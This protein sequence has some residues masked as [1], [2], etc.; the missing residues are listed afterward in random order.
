MVFPCKFAQADLKPVSDSAPR[1]YLVTPTVF[2]AHTFAQDLEQ[3][4][5]EVGVACVRLAL[6]DASGEED[7][8]S[9]VNHLL[10][11]C[12][13]ADVPLVVTDHYRLVEPLGLDGV[14][15]ANS[16]TPLREVRKALGDD[17]IVGAYAGNSRHDGMVLAEAGAEYI[18]FGPVGD[19]GALG[20]E[21]RVDDEMFKWW[22]EMIETPVV[23][24]GAVRP[25]DAARLTEFADFVVPDIALWQSPENAVAVLRQYEAA[26]QT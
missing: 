23:A 2:D 5:G 25:E 6:P 3:V 19:T 21:N 26:L 20:D 4:L 16:R 15:L 9:A 8:T 24:E 22:A 14:H 10:P 1:I 7:W 13:Q 17:R 18:C 11:V 12:H